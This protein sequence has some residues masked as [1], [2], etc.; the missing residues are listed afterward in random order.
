MEINS[1]PKSLGMIGGGVLALGCFMPV[2]S[3]PIMGNITYI[4]NGGGDGLLVLIAAAA[5]AYFSHRESRK[6]MLISGFIAAAIML[7]TVINIQVRISQMKAEMAKSIDGMPEGMDNMLSGL[8]EA[9]A[10][11][12]QMQWGWVILMIGVGLLLY[13]GFKT[14][15]DA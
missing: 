11:S 3:V 15:A 8:G 10:Q 4:A 1:E 12:V 2:L 5:G 13:A 7:F 6:G 9:L 14:E